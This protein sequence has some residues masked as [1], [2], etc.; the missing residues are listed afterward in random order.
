MEYDY[1]LEEQK[2]KI[3]ISKTKD[4]FE[5]VYLSY[6]HK[7]YRS[8]IVMLWSV[9]VCDIIYKLQ[10]LESLYNDL[11]AK[12]ILIEY[13]KQYSDKSKSSEWEKKLVENVF[14]KTLLIDFG[15]METIKHIQQYRHISA[16]PV[17][18][19]NYELYVPNKDLCRG[20]IISALNG[21]LIK[22]AFFTKKIFDDFLADISINKQ[23]LISQE[24]ISKYLEAKYLKYLDKTV[25]LS[26]VKSLWK[27]VFKVD[28]DE[29]NENR[30]INR[31]VL[32]ILVAKNINEIEFDIKK[33]Q[34]YYSENISVNNAKITSSLYLF[35]FQFPS[36]YKLLREDAQVL[37]KG[38]REA[39]AHTLLTA[40]F[41]YDSWDDFEKELMQSISDI[42]TLTKID[43]VLDFDMEKIREIYCRNK[44]ENILYKVFIERLSISS[45]FNSAD[46][47]FTK[48][49]EPYIAEMNLDILL[50]LIEGIEK[51][52]QVYSRG[53]AK[54]DHKQIK[55]RII[56][57]KPDQNF[58]NYEC[59]NIAF[60]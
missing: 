1:S 11:N 20:L 43:D 45:N 17:L 54:H 26:F 44:V 2:E 18:E 9:I 41:L 30:S 56:E 4:Y 47:N 27:L 15:T 25:L 10:E 8:C 6:Q 59:F 51:N 19:T 42:K 23:V 57:L 39:Y 38:K 22:P 12:E 58:D 55:D 13:N 21:I 53:R 7:N 46:S 16:H 5:E 3:A 28:N 40:R 52:N 31:R 33:E 29:C 49:I 14:N 36:L 24:Q 60:S 32:D 50:L 48:Y 35:L 37:I 34:K